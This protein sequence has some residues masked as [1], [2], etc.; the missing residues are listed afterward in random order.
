MILNSHW[1]AKKTDFP[2]SN[3]NYIDNRFFITK[4]KQQDKLLS[5]KYPTS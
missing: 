3:S 4:S 5:L 2:E 1:R